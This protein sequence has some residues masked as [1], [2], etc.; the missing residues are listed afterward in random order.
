MKRILVCLSAMLLV[1]AVDGVAGAI[2]IN[3]DLAGVPNSKVSVSE[4]GAGWIYA[5][6]DSNLGNETFSLADGAT[7]EIDFFGL[8]VGGL[9]FGTP[10]TISA[11]LAFDLPHI[12]AVG[13]S[14]GEF[15]TIFGVLSGGTLQW[16]SSTLPDAFTIGNDV[17]P[18]DF[19]NGIACGIGNTATVHAYITNDATSPVPEPATMMLL[20]VG[21][22]GL[23]GF[24]RK[25]LRM[26]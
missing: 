2:P 4:N 9:S 14:S 5:T 17:V 1:L 3:F 25:R 16:D 15:F 19:E 18:V 10:Y 20:G 6:L 8:T 13:S 21:L 12:V 22:V 24:G 11:T 23:A 7:R 26:A